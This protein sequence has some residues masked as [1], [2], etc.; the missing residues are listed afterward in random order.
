MDVR[1]ANTRYPQV[2]KVSIID[3]AFTGW[4]GHNAAYDLS[5]CSELSKRSIVCQVFAHCGV[6]T[7]GLATHPNVL[8]T[9]KQNT[10]TASFEIKSAPAV[11]NRILRLAVLNYR[12][13]VDLRKKVSSRVTDG[14]VIL[15][16]IESRYTS[17]AYGLWLFTLFLKRITLTCVFVLHNIPSNI[18]RWEILFVRTLAIRHRTVLAAHTNAIA[19]LCENTTGQAC[20]VLPL[21]FNSDRAHRVPAPVLREEGILFVYLGIASFAKGFDIIVDAIEGIAGM[22]ADGKIKLEIQC[23][24]REE[25]ERITAAHEA[26]VGRLQAIRGIHLISGPLSSVEY[27]AEMDNADVILIP[28]RS[29]FYRH[30]L[31]GVFTESL[32]RGK[33]VIVAEDTYMAKELKRHGAGVTFRSGS[34]TSLTNAIA[35]ATTNIETLRQK[36]LAAREAWSKRHNPERFVDALL[37]LL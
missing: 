14:D 31:S 10:H 36:A 35:N 18:I 11:V 33:P 29:E 3:D 23:N 1:T 7:S 26:L 4:T 21:P 28:N 13:F 37:G 34:A 25:N 2:V 27:G 15:V 16:A 30:A 5:I 12:H 22:L 9:F 17:F 19:E 20:Y 24:L 32:S 8:P 6:R